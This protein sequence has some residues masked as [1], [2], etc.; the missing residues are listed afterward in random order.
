MALDAEQSVVASTR[1]CAAG[2]RERARAC[3]ARS[4]PRCARSSTRRGS[5][6]ASIDYAQHRVATACREFFDWVK[7]R[8]H[9]FR[10]VTFGTML[11]DEAYQFIRLGTF[12]ERADNTARILDVK[13]HIAA[14]V[15]GGRRRRASTTTSGS[16]LLRSVSALRD[17]PQDLSRRDHAVKRRRAADP[18]RRHAALA[19]RVHERN[20]RHPAQRCATMP[21]SRA[22]RVGGELHARLHYGRTRRS[23]IS[24][25][26]S[27]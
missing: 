23:S 20:L 13:Y 5:R 2:A 6:C 11:R 3:A 27:T 18:A 22:E 25:C 7:K 10:G 24:A 15:G 9:L 14:A 8:S 1:A 19:A 16:A 21:R 17:L 26:T 4:P 12:L